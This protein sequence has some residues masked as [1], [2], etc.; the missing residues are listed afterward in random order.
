MNAASPR[1]KIQADLFAEAASNADAPQS[2][3]EA[4]EAAA[5]CRRCHLW[6]YATQ[7]VFGEGPGS[8]TVVFVGEQ[9]GDQ[10]DLAGKPFVGP[11]GKMFDA[12]LEDADFDRKKTYVTNAVKHF[13][14]EPRGRKRIHSKPNAGEIQACHWWLHSELKLIKP[15]LAVAL[16]ATAAQ[17]LLGRAIPVTKLRGT[18]VEREDGL[19]IFVTVHPSYLLRIPDEVAKQAER[20]RFLDDMRK[21]KKLAGM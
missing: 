13:K 3:R 18:T 20:R 9:P 21:V 2:L 19:K 8:A 1:G 15:E 17:S 6:E 16:G 14:F 10:E 4:R 11:A 7:T 5:T 12:V